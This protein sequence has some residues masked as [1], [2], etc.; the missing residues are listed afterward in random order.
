MGLLSKFCKT[1]K[2]QDVEQEV[3]DHLTTLL[4]TKQGYGAWQKGLGMQS[5]SSGKDRSDTIKDMIEDLKVNIETYEK[6]IQIVSIEAEESKNSLIPR[7]KVKCKIGERFH[8]FFIGFKKS[9]IP[10]EVEVA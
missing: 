3:A 1:Q 6:R 4:N 7:F 9:Q 10:I 2:R 8:S 5:Y